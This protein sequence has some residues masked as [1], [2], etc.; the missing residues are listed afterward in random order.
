MTQ[1]EILIRLLHVKQW[2]LTKNHIFRVKKTFSRC[3]WIYDL[4]GNDGF[5]DAFLF[6]PL[7]YNIVWETWFVDR[8]K[9]K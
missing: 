2:S 5:I 7:A 8:A 1:I 9:I 6:N 4:S 3:F